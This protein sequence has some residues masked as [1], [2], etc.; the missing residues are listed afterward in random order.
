MSRN[1]ASRS[2]G[3]SGGGDSSTAMIILGGVAVVAVGIGIMVFLRYREVSTPLDTG[4]ADD[5]SETLASD[6]AG[7]ADS[8]SVVI[9]Q[10]DGKGSQGGSITTSV[11]NQQDVRDET[12]TDDGRRV[13]A[14]LRDIGVK[15]SALTEDRRGAVQECLAN[16]VTDELDRARLG[17]RA[18]E[19]E[20]V[21]VITPEIRRIKGTPVLWADAVLYGR[22]K[23]PRVRLWKRS[24]QIA[25]IT[26][27]ALT[28]AILPP[29]LDR[30][31]AR[32][33]QSLRNSVDDAR[34]QFAN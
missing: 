17:Q 23:E 27:K 11:Q 6:E 18:G 7:G 34:K 22:I 26:D 33:L 20:P 10:K 2:A 29:N 19:Q 1:S 28:A 5:G 30:D 15:I 24:G 31:V 3:P 12:G 9:P 4:A 8:D 25:E 32:F 14:G 21:L 13:L 16:G